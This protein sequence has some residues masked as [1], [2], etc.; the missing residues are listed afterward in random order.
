MPLFFSDDAR[1]RRQA[2]GHPDGGAGRPVRP[3]STVDQTPDHG[4]AGDHVHD[5]H[6]DRPRRRHRRG[7]LRPAD[8]P[9]GTQARPR[10]AR[11]REPCATSSAPGGATRCTTCSSPTNS[12]RTRPTGSDSCRRS[13]SRAHS[14]TGRSNWHERCC[15]ARPPR[16]G[17]RSPTL[18]WHSTTTN[19]PPSPPIPAMERAVQATDDFQE[20]I[21]S[22]VER[23]AQPSRAADP[24][25]V[26][27]F[28]GMALEVFPEDWE[29]GLAVVAHPDDMEYGAAAAVARWTRQGKRFA[30]VLVSDGERGSP[31]WTRP[32]QVPCGGGSSRRAAPSSASTT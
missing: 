29:R 12:A 9:A 4:G 14:A 22:F 24:R 31:R 25:T 20:G 23:R 2:Q 10:P 11:R 5:R 16:C 27:M 13:S 6:R 1:A 32:R 3:R 30:Y 15:S 28:T 17:T 19:S 21:A 26:T 8:V 7:R 18:A